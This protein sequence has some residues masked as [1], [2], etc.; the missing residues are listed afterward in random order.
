MPRP[1]VEKA[2]QDIIEAYQSQQ[3]DF[4]KMWFYIN[5]T[6]HSCLLGDTD[7]LMT[8]DVPD[9]DESDGEHWTAEEY[10]EDHPQD[11]F[12][13]EEREKIKVP[14]D[15]EMYDMT[16]SVRLAIEGDMKN[17]LLNPKT[18]EEDLNLKKRLGMIKGK[19]MQ[20]LGREYK[21]HLESI[22]EDDWQ[23]LSNIM[24]STKSIFFGK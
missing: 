8:G 4:D 6:A 13:K 22:P 20:E 3:N 11:Y 10:R 15:Q 9:P 14:I 23:I 21:K 18:L 16:D 2:Q 17:T 24:K 1:D 7:M 19:I 5:Q 12:S